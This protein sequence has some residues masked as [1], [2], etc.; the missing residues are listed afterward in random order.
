M[1]TDSR[2]DFNTRR[3]YNIF[4]GGVYGTGR[5]SKRQMLMSYSINNIF[6][7]KYY[8]KKDSI[9]KKIKIFDNIR[10]NGNYNFAADSLKFSTVSLSGTT[11][12]LKGMT[13]F[14]VSASWDPYTVN[15]NNQRINKSYWRTNGKLLRFLRADFRLNT[16][17]SVSSLKKLFKKEK[18]RANISRD[19]TNRRGSGQTNT[20][21]PEESF[22]K[23]L[24]GFNLNHS[25]AFN[26]SKDASQN[27]NWEIRTHSINVTVRQIEVTENWSVGIGNIGY[28]FK[29]K[30]TTYPD[31]RITRDLHCW[32]AF[33]SW[34]PQRGTYYF[35]IKVKNPPLDALKIPYRKNNADAFGGF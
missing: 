16:R 18:P 24:E 3:S 34:Q 17:M 33:F 32:E 27:T 20:Q 4:Q 6:E 35:T 12:F 11:R 14:S 28:D 23:F 29:N 31:F 22:L 21:Q 10:V 1:D 13:T 5:S 2:E 7:A 25:L 30:R 8:S 26:A 9:D 15:E 19:N